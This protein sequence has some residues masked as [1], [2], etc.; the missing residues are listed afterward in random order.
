[1]REQYDELIPDPEVRRELGVTA[2]TTWRWDHDAEM[3]AQGWPER[4][5]IKKRG[6]RSRR[7]FEKFKA[8]LLRQATQARKLISEV[9]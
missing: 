6:Y 8:A 9:A 5:V 2:M 7:Q 4:L 3:A 1:M